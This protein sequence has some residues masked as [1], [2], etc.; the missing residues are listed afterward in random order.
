M[1]ESVPGRAHSD[2][3]ALRVG[4]TTQAVRAAK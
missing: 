1:I 4:E 3:R 2:E